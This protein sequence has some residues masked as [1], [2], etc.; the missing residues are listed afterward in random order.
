MTQGGGEPPKF[1]VFGN[2][3]KVPEPYRRY[4]A[5]RLRRHLGLTVTPIV[6]GFRRRGR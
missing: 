3:R 1:I 6:L 2:G 4:M 5:G